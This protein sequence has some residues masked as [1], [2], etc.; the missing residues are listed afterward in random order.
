MSNDNER[1]EFI[2][3]NGKTFL[4]VGFVPQTA[5]TFWGYGQ[6]PITA[7]RNAYKASYEN[8]PL[9]IWCA[10]GDYNNLD[11]TDYGHLSWHTENPVP[12]GV[13]KVTKNSIS[14]ALTA[15]EGCKMTCKEWIQSVH[16]ICEKQEQS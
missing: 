12:V 15:L 2:Q 4:A 14:P 7:I 1:D 10:Y 8:K 3:S 13:F 6:D 5:V 11:C 9:A 16:D